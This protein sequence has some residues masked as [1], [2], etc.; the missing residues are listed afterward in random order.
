MTLE[1]IKNTKKYQEATL[2]FLTK[3]DIF[4]YNFIEFAPNIRSEIESASQNPSCSCKK[5]I[6]DF[7]DENT[8]TYLN[9]LYNFLVD[10]NLLYE[11]IIEINQ[12]KDYILL[13]GKILKTSVSDWQDFCL[14]LEKQNAQFRSFSILKE[15]N[16]ILV[17]FL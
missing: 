5:K 3:N 15:G 2:S 17:F 10:N 14:E 8:E 6:V 9:F 7:I 11:F 16:D 4:K 12:I 1:E 13:T